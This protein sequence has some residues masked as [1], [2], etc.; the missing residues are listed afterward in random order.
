MGSGVFRTEKRQP[1][2]RSIKDTCANALETKEFVVN[3]M[4]DWAVEAE[5]YTWYCAD[6]S[7]QASSRV[8]WFLNNLARAA[9]PKGATALGA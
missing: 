4:S 2:V 9:Y 6:P 3:V 5:N 1:D 7:A 8:K